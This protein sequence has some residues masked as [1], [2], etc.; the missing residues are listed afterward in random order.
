MVVI[1][2]CVRVLQQRPF[3]MH[4]FIPLQVCCSC[5]VYVTGGRGGIHLEKSPGDKNPYIVPFLIYGNN[6][7]IILNTVS[8][9]AAMFSNFVK[10]YGDRQNM[11]VDTIRI[12]CENICTAAVDEHVGK[13]RML[14]NFQYCST[15]TLYV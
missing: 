14:Q 3:E 15:I 4:F 1:Y 11:V 13:L 12:L 2:N 6:I 7:I 10:T 8:S 9:F 5:S